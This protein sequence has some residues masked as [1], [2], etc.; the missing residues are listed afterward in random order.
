[1][2]DWLITKN[3]HDCSVTFISM[4]PLTRQR[5]L[6]LCDRV[7]VG[8]TVHARLWTLLHRA[9]L[10][11]ADQNKTRLISGTIRILVI[12]MLWKYSIWY[13]EEIEILGAVC[14]AHSG[15]DE[16]NWSESLESGSQCQWCGPRPS[17]LGQDRSETKKSVLVLQVGCV[18]KHGLVTLVMM[19]LNDTATFQ[20][21]FTV[22][23]FWSWNIT[24]VKINS[25]VHLLRS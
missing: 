17:V 9:R 24:T 21:L 22:S 13:M 2:I 6:W 10:A 15:V 18:V 3:Q 23:L 11:L 12:K 7:A 20:V 19:I 16:M 8:L 25:G 14:S 5:R 4:R 1:M